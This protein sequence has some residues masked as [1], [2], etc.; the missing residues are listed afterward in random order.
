MLTLVLLGMYFDAAVVF[1]KTFFTFIQIG[2]GHTVAKVATV[3][4]LDEKVVKSETP[5]SGK[6]VRALARRL[7]ACQ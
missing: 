5:R 6:K 3:N 4:P 7:L 1:I 2:S